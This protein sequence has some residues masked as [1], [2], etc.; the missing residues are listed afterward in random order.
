MRGSD[1]RVR[2]L[3]RAPGPGESLPGVG[4]SAA[5]RC[6]RCRGRS[7]PRRHSRGP[8]ESDV[9]A[10]NG[11]GI[12]YSDARRYPDARKAFTQVL[13]L[14]PTNGLAYQNL[15]FVSLSEAHAA[16]DPGMRAAKLKEAESAARQAVTT[17]PSLA[18]A[19]TTLGV[20]LSESGRKSDAIDSWKHAVDLDG[21]AFDALYNLWAELAAAGRREEA[22]AY[23]RQFVATAPPALYGADIER[24]RRYLG[25]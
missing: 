6:R 11:L 2:W 25:T 20:I 10:L 4:D 14:D 8:P 5:H 15:A 12:A 9:E 3:D 19:F 22:V 21:T 24:V 18:G 23:G 17:D 13:A 16:R 7:T 1:T